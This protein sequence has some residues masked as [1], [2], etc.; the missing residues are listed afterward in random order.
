M[1]LTHLSQTTCNILL[2]QYVTCSAHGAVQV[3]SCR[4]KLKADSGFI[5]QLARLEV[6]SQADLIIYFS[7]LQV[8]IIYFSLTTCKLQ[9]SAVQCRL[10]VRLI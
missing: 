4:L 2:S 10:E 1:Q 9:C 5:V 8:A 3:V 7:L 6:N